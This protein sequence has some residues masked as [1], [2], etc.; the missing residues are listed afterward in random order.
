MADANVPTVW[1]TPVDEAALAAVPRL[2]CLLTP[3]ET[4]RTERLLFAKD[5][6]LHT[7]ARAHVR[8]VLSCYAPIA[9]DTWR[10]EY[11]DQG[12]PAILNPVPQPLHFSLTHTPGLVASVVWSSPWCGID[13]EDTQRPVKPLELAR[14][15]FAPGEVAALAAMDGAEQRQHFFELWTL[16]E[17]FAKATGQGLAIGLERVSFVRTGLRIDATLDASLH[18]DASQWLFHLLRP[19]PH[20]Q[21][22]VALRGGNGAGAIG[23]RVETLTL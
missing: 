16:K 23:L 14:S 13:A 4:A 17:S 8:T 22:G 3:E 6:V 19:T 18:E 21:L 10:F 12:R 11:T 5:R 7:V 15:T 20:H 9:A 1:L 2:A